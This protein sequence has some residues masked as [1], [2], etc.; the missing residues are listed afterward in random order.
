M[1]HAPTQLGPRELRE[2]YAEPFA[3]AIRDAGLASIMNVYSSVDGL[4]CAGLV[5]DPDRPAPRRVG[6]RRPRR[7]RL[8]RRVDADHPP[9]HRR[10]PSG[11]CRAGAGGGA[12]PRIAGVRLLPRARP[13][14]GGRN[15]RHRS[16][17]PGRGARARE[18]VPARALRAAVRRRGSSS[19]GVRDRDATRAGAAAAARS[20]VLLRNEDEPACRSELRGRIAVVGPLADSVRGLQ[21]DYHYPAHSELTYE[22]DEQ[23]AAPVALPESGGAFSP[24]PHFTDHVTPARSDSGGSPATVRR[25]TSSVGCAIDGDDRSELDA[26]VALARS[27]DVAIVCVGGESGL[28]RHSTVGE[29]RDASDLSLTG[30]QQELVESVVATGTP[31]VVVVIGGRVFAL[32]WIAANVPAVLM[33]WLP[34]EEGGN[35]IA[36]VLTGVTN[37]VRTAARHVPP[38]GGPGA[39][40][41]RTPVRRRTI[42]VLGRLHRRTDLAAVPVRPRALVHDVRLRRLARTTGVDA[43][44]D[45]RRGHDHQHGPA[46][47]RRGRAAVRD[48]R[49]RVGRPS[50]T[51]AR[52][53]SG[54]S[55]SNRASRQ[56]ADVRRAP[57]PAGVLRP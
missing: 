5:I 45:R 25:S 4:P 39:D 47:R 9:S 13:V 21:G 7:R 23:R 18:Q 10:R 29:A 42:T 19:D 34:G 3:A 1:N 31:T 17:R 26:A 51:A 22:R 55:S 12:R 46:R 32:P 48:R 40:L 24:G 50:T 16:R 57:E 41:R 49:S 15:R 44:R 27:A 53:A 14:G 20:V 33:A 8:L 38:L 35:A 28:M 2:V 52:S 54:G 30:L 11:G 36:D 43:R 56:T 6:L 37:P